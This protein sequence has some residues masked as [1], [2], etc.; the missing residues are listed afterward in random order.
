MTVEV[1]FLRRMLKIWIEKK[2]NENVFEEAGVHRTLMKRIRQRQLAF[3]GH[4]LRKHGLENLMVTRRIDGKKAKGRQRLKYLDSSCESRTDKVSPTELIRASEDRL[5][6]QRMVA[7]VVDDG[8]AAWH[9][10]TDKQVQV[11]LFRSRSSE[12]QSAAASRRTHTQ[13]YQRFWFTLNF[14]TMA[15]YQIVFWLY[16]DYNISWQKIGLVLGRIQ[17]DWT[18]L[19]WILKWT[20]C[21][22]ARF[23]GYS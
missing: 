5:L 2:S 11:D 6:R 3:L 21:Q 23:L 12:K 19:N 8:T 15:L 7:N 22:F 18:E 9:D 13:H 17:N 4:M 1:W 10:M 14:V 20:D 16:L